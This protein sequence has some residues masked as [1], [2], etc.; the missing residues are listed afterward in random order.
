MN[1]VNASQNQT[2]ATMNLKSLPNLPLAMRFL[3]KLMVQQRLAAGTNVSGVNL[4][5]CHLAGQVAAAQQFLLPAGS[6]CKRLAQ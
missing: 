1:V 4:A 6:F 2:L 3:S 5:E